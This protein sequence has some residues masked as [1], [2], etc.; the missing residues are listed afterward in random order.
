MSKQT[1][2]GRIVGCNEGGYYKVVADDAPQH[3]QTMFLR[4]WEITG[5]KE[6]GATGTLVYRTSSR[7][8]LWYLT[9]SSR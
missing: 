4:G 8:G 2:Q 9:G 1:Y 5:C 7:G 6:I 3:L